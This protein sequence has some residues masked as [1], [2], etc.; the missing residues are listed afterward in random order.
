MRIYYT[1]LL[2]EAVKELPPMG[3]EATV[4]SEGKLLQVV[5]QM[6]ARNA[7]LVDAKKPPLEEGGDAVHPWQ[8]RLAFRGFSSARSRFMNIAGI[9]HMGVG[10]PAVSYDRRGWGHRLLNE[11]SQLIMG[12]TGYDLK[13]KTPHALISNLDGSGYHGLG[14]MR[15]T[16]ARTLAT[17]FAS[18]ADIDFIDLNLTAQLLAVRPDHGPTQL[19]ETHP[20]RSIAPKS[21]CSLE[22]QG[23]QPGLLI[24]DPPDSPKP[25]PE[26]QVAA[27]EN[28]SRGRRNH[29][30]TI[31]AP[32]GPSRQ[33]PAL[34][35]TASRTP[36]A[37]GPANLD[38]I[39]PAALFCSK[40]TFK[41]HQIS[42]E[43][44]CHAGSLFS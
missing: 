8:K 28:G 37:L 16:E 38:Q 17:S 27:M 14:V 25:E 33:Q 24:G 5:G 7:S 34:P 15:H 11:S 39:I 1:G 41:F 19:V 44:P 10:K 20:G 4:E 18:A 3:R 22:P 31:A 40:L 12:P 21:Q 2:H 26:R 42:R 35:V 32:P 30:A 13:T 9:L 29:G 23:A 6:L 43:E 36:E